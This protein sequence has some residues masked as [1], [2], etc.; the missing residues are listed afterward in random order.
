MCE[1]LNN[2]KHCCRKNDNETKEQK[3]TIYRRSIFVVKDTKKGE[4][5]TTENIRIIRPAF[6]LE[7]KYYENIIGKK[8]KM[9]L[10]FGTPLHQEHIEW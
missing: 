6:G 5:F 9:D 3:N 7:P 4:L 2:E 1:N 10:E 8:A